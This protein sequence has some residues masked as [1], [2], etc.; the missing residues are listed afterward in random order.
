M[1][2][3]LESKQKDGELR[4]L[5]TVALPL[6]PRLNRPA[7][8]SPVAP[9]N[10]FVRDWTFKKGETQIKQEEEKKAEEVDIP[11]ESQEVHQDFSLKTGNPFLNT[12]DSIITESM[13]EVI[14]PQTS[15]LTEEKTAHLDENALE[16]KGLKE[17][18][19]FLES[20]KLQ[21]RVIYGMASMPSQSKRIL[22]F[23]TSQ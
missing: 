9:T 13:T 22:G 5:K 21:N 2:E 11:K 1:A 6:T 23:G 10:P 3:S 12:L 7:Q 8:L 20:K 17:F 14:I 18:V 4:S 19:D 16:N 15:A